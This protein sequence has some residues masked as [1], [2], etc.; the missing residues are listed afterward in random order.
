M[1]DKMIPLHVRSS[2]KEENGAYAP[3]SSLFSEAREGGP[4]RL[5]KIELEGKTLVDNALSPLVAEGL[6]GKACPSQGRLFVSAF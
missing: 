2:P 5:L 1:A 6:G 3:F 4:V